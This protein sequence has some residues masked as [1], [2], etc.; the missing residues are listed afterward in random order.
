MQKVRDE[1]KAPLPMDPPPR[2]RSRSRSGAS[3]SRAPGHDSYNAPPWQGQGAIGKCNVTGRSKDKGNETSKGKEKG[4]G[5]GDDQTLTHLV[6]KFAEITASI[7]EI[8]DNQLAP[9]RASRD[10]RSSQIVSTRG[11]QQIMIHDLKFLRSAL[12][13]ANDACQ[14]METVMRMSSEQFKDNATIIQTAMAT[15]D[16]VTTQVQI[17]N[18]TGL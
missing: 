13:R 10:A 3:R 6:E 14:K 12:E 17:L 15:L 4:K 9:V 18:T 8:R 7:A 16:H 2:R 11:P 5:N 1:R